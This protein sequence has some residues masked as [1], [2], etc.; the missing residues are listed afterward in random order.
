MSEED[1]NKVKST[2]NPSN[3]RLDFPMD[4]HVFFV[5]FFPDMRF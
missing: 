3:V 4:C 5:I 2:K 1:V